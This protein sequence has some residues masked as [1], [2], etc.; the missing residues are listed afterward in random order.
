MKFTGI[1][2][3]KEDEEISFEQFIKSNELCKN[4]EAIFIN[5]QV[6]FFDY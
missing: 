6:Y 2:K 4:G 3:P 5:V 1:I